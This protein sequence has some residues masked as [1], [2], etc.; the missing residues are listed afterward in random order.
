AERIRRLFPT[1]VVMEEFGSPGGPVTGP[2]AGPVPA[3]GE[4]PQQLGD[5][6]SCGRWAAAAW[7]SSTR[8]GKNRSAATTRCLSALQGAFA[9]FQLPTSP[10][11]RLGAMPVRYYSKDS[12]HSLLHLRGALTWRSGWSGNWAAMPSRISG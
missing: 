10:G 9:G 7:A 3:T 5:T 4:G 2:F 12:L 1:L 6:A 8:R 11:T